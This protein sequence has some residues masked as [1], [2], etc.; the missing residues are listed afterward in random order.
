M[1]VKSSNFASL[2]YLF[3]CAQYL[4]FNNL[5][6]NYYQHTTPMNNPKRSVSPQTVTEDETSAT[7]SGFG[8]SS[9]VSYIKGNLPSTSSFQQ[10]SDSSQTFIDISMIEEEELMND[11]TSEKKRR[12]SI[13]G[14]PRND[15]IPRSSTLNNNL[16]SYK[17]YYE[18]L[19]TSKQELNNDLERRLSTVYG[20]GIVRD[21]AQEVRDSA[22]AA[23][24][25]YIKD[26]SPLQDITRDSVG[27]SI[28]N[29]L[30][31]DTP[32]D[33]L[34]LEPE[35]A[36]L[37]VDEE[38]N[39]VR[40]PM[41]NLDPRER[42]HLLQLK[43]SLEISQSLQN[44]IKY[45][46]D[47]KETNSEYMPASNKVETSTQTNTLGHLSNN[48]SFCRNKRKL[49]SKKN[50]KTSKRARN[51]KGFFVGEFYYDVQENDDSKVKN[52]LNGYLGSINKPKFKAENQSDDHGSK[53]STQKSTSQRVGLD[54][55]NT[56]K[57]NLELDSEY[58]EKS[59]KMSNIIKLK[60]TK[61]KVDEIADKGKS[62]EAP[63]SGFQFSINKSDMESI[64][65]KRNATN[66]LNSKRPE[67]SISQK[68]PTMSKFSFGTT[69]SGPEAPKLSFGAKDTE[70]STPT[71]FSLG[72]L[73]K[74]EEMSSAPSEK[75]GFS[76]S[77]DK[78]SVK[79]GKE[80]KK[81][82]S[83]QPLFS[84]GAKSEEKEK[85]TFSLGKPEEKEKST[86]SFGKPEEKKERT[87]LFGATTEEKKDDS[88]STFLFGAKPTE[89][90]D[91]KS[92]ISVKKPT[93]TFSF[94]AK[95][96]EKKEDSNPTFSFGAKPEDNKEPPRESS[97]EPPKESTPTFSFGAEAKKDP[98]PTFSFGAKPQDKKEETPNFSFGKP[99]GETKLFSFTSSKN[100]RTEDDE[101]NVKRKTPA[102]NTL[103]GAATPAFSFGQKK[104]D[105]P[106][107]LGKKD[108]ASSV[109]KSVSPVVFGGDKAGGDA[110]PAFNF[111]GASSVAKEPTNASSNTSFNFGAPAVSDP[112]TI[113]G[114]SGPEK[115][116]FSFGQTAASSPK[117]GFSFGAGTTAT[118]NA[119]TPAK[120]FAFAGGA[121]SNPNFKFAAGIT[122]SPNT[123]TPKFNFG[124]QSA[125]N[126][127]GGAPNFAG[128]RE[129]TPT[130][131]F[132]NNN[133]NANIG[134]PQSTFNFGSREGT[135]DPASIFGNPSRGTTPNFMA[136]GTA[137]NQN[138][139]GLGANPAGAGFGTNISMPQP[140]PGFQFSAP[141]GNSA[142]TPPIP[143]NRKIAQYRL[144]RR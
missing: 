79:L 87:T 126:L 132:A 72:N 139:S 65:N 84:F 64:V 124:A 74:Q 86:F 136:G 23:L 97:K 69:T 24:Q 48:L 125:P 49:E 9:L 46:V 105:T 56:N 15:S 144:R 123:G 91:Q 39:L 108:G 6:E 111:G 2:S 1:G 128:S 122:Q 30:Q 27:G 33:Q 107:G 98:A 142:P 76:F 4:I 57:V 44:R 102:S 20:Q 113:F 10:Q 14:H 117:P 96:T 93:P 42:Y 26:T 138:N 71:P 101:E 115:P 127:S 119:S 94:G 54:L 89:K 106:F 32:E 59:E 7:K 35:F 43:I 38:G 63:S 40:P 28:L 62:S 95:P 17:T 53:Y 77:S 134:Q 12:L 118:P 60:G 109:E 11:F 104:E 143:S 22:E 58:L 110:K 75:P 137:Y 130:F 45:M 67:S 29:Q 5:I 34:M 135:P 8:I 103:F 31:Y 51:N 21:S 68:K 82:S 37:Y 83:A 52:D 85:S 3:R 66:E 50:L 55:L 114:V 141:S 129:A 61:D 13:Q 81:E 131:G 140:T 88:K 99:A 70:N 18:N 90:D 25:Q 92:E 112:S 100:P 121:P 78:P 120:P 36:P 73:S 19:K 133:P 16:G 116:A 47:P 41:I 80:D